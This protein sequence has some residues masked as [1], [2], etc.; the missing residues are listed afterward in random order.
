MKRLKKSNY[1]VDAVTA[2][3]MLLGKW[4][5]RRLEDGTVL[6]ARIVETEAV[7]IRGIEDH[8]GPGRT[9]KFLQIDRTINREPLTTSKRLWIEDDGTQPLRFKTT[10]RIGIAYATKRDQNRKWRF[11]V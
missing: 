6:K 5:C 4:L 2:A 10:P 11:V 3:K 7:L 8:I 1:A 9:T